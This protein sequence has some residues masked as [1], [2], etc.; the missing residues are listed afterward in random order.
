MKKF[1][2]WWTVA[3]VEDHRRLAELVGTSTTY[4]RSHVMAGRRPVSAAY[5]AVVE[6]A[7]RH[8]NRKARDKPL[9]DLDRRDL[10]E[11]CRKCPFAA[12]EK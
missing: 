11:T 6:R 9:P 4:L 8:V 1:L 3:S 10:C 2:A 5:A 7:V 12:E